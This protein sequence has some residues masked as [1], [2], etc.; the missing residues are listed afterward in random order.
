MR[1]QLQ[2]AA[3]ALAVAGS[4]SFAAAESYAL[5][6]KVEG[7]RNNK[8]DVQF[9]LY[10]K[11]GT[12][13][14]KHYTKYYKKA[15]APIRNGKATIVFR[16][17]PKGRYAVNVLH[18]EDKNGQIAMGLMLPDEGIGFSNYSSIGIGNKPSFEKAS[19]EV[20]HDM[21]KSVKVIYL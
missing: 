21:A 18:D 1:G 10:N 17:L 11:K 14:D 8:G 5:K 4:L 16:G 15:V 2:I 6:V 9:A 7:L 13:P 20:D 3:I 12:I 19:F